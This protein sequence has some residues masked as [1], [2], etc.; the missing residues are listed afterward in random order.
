LLV[1]GGGNEGAVVVGI[2]LASVVVDESMIAV[3][4]VGEEGRRHDVGGPEEP[5]PAPFNT[6]NTCLV[7]ETCGR[8]DFR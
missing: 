1:S 8:S 7:A 5:G 3:P 2:G 6:T 4:M